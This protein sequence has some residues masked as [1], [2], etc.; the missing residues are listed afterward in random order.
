MLH[1]LVLAIDDPLAIR[2]P[3]GPLGAVDR[4][5]GGGGSF[6]ATVQRHQED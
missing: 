2:Q 5:G 6:P 3:I 4:A 1:Q